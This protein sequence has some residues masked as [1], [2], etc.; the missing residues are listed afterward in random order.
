MAQ[1]ISRRNYRRKHRRWT[2]KRVKLA[3][4]ILAIVSLFAAAVF[5]L[6]STGE[7]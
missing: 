3:A 6:Q 2:K 4:E 7:L 1:K 5:A